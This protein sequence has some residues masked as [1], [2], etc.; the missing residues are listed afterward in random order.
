MNID[1]NILSEL[2][3]RHDYD[4]TII[5]HAPGKG[6]FTK[7]SIEVIEDIIHIWLLY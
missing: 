1:F 6:P 5:F 3:L 2:S 4:K 7:F